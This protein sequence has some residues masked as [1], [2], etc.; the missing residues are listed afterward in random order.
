MAL[1]SSSNVWKVIL[2]IFLIITAFFVLCF[3]FRTIFITIV[4]GIVMIIM[5]EKLMK[6][7]RKKINRSDLSKTRRKILGAGLIIFWVF[8]I[9]FL[10]WNSLEDLSGA[11]GEARK[12]QQTA[13]GVYL[14][15]IDP[16][17]PPLVAKNVLTEKRIKEAENYVFSVFSEFFSKIANLLLNAVLI[18]PLMFAMYYKRGKELT[19]KVVKHMP[20]KFRGS[21]ERAMKDI[22][23]ETHDY[24][25][26]KIIETTV[27]GA[28]C[29]LGFFVAG[30]KG[31]LVLG[32][33]AGFLNIVPYIGPLIGAIPPVLITL[34]VDKPIA[35]I[36]VIIAVIVAQLVDNL[37]LN[38]FMI[39]G[40]VKID[41]LLSIVVIL[42]GAQ[43]FGAIGMIFAIPI[44]LVYKIILKEAYR[45][46][47]RIYG[48]G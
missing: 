13:S 23:S 15:K 7:Y 34:L 41:P 1:S 5:S 44:Y 22:A 6:H 27:V 10:V 25:E 47:T 18:I 8:S 17:M 20:K 45:E 24:L 36:Y 26:G 19:K 42:I 31:W 3:Y 39:S 4:V 35:A 9:I 33:L 38:P 46:L 32:L 29:C 28:I 48:S 43:L 37:Y 30:V 2:V 12:T 40:K 11:I 21:C 14:M 16:Y